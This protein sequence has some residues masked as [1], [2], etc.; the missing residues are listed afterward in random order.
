MN[1]LKEAVKVALVDHETVNTQERLADFLGMSASQFSRALN[2]NKRSFTENQRFVLAG[3][4]GVTASAMTGILRN[5]AAE[6]IARQQGW[7]EAAGISKMV[8]LQTQVQA[9][10]DQNKLLADQFQT[11]AGIGDALE[12]AAKTI[13]D[14][15]KANIE[16]AK[17]ISE[18]ARKLTGFKNDASGDGSATQ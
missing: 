11:F 7:S 10:A 3:F 6:E 9:L 12:K 13:T 5:D 16:Q 17:L 2:N 8:E 1:R 15:H 18:Q 4:L 14:L